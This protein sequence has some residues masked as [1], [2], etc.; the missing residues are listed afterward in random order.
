MFFWLHQNMVC[1]DG[2]GLSSAQDPVRA[3]AK[4]TMQT[5]K[6]DVCHFWGIKDCEKYALQKYY[7]PKKQN[8]DLIEDC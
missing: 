3:R 2:A 4:I 1:R 7:Q 5:F 8:I 6:V